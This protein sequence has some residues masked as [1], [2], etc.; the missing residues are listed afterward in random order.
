L[1]G[2]LYGGNTVARIDQFASTD[3][4]TGEKTPEIQRMEYFGL[5]HQLGAVSG[6]SAPFLGQSTIAEFLELQRQKQTEE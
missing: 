4:D 2:I 6:L 5:S 3:P 1:I